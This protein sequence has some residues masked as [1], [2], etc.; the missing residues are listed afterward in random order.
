YSTKERRL[1]RKKEGFVKNNI[2]CSHEGS[3]V[4]CK[5]CFWWRKIFKTYPG[6]LSSLKVSPVYCSY[7]QRRILKNE[8]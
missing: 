7:P 6:L 4:A 1:S 3:D 8:D 2:S 5:K